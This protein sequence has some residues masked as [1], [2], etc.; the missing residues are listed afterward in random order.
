M[1]NYFGQE[2]TYFEMCLSKGHV[3]RCW[4]TSFTVHNIECLVLFSLFFF[5]TVNHFFKS[6]VEGFQASM[7]G[8]QAT[9]F[10]CVADI[11]C[12]QHVWLDWGAP[13]QK[14]T[15][16]LERQPTA[17]RAAESSWKSGRLGDPASDGLVPSC[18]WQ[19]RL[20]YP[21]GSHQLTAHRS[22]P[23][24]RKKAIHEWKSQAS[25]P[26]ERNFPPQK[27]RKTA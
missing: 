8:L 7:S 16:V 15:A 22:R 11:D 18:E 25:E 17:Q 13:W 19:A 10:F 2:N 4:T 23:V 26:C 27:K 9:I 5:R 6:S 12:G 3:E 14:A 1:C 21:L 24:G 20:H